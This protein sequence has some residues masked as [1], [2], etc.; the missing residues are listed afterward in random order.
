LPQLV[1]LKLNK[2]KTHMHI[3]RLLLASIERFMLDMRQFKRQ[4]E[5]KMWQHTP[6]HAYTHTHTH[7]HRTY[8]YRKLLNALTLQLFRVAL[9]STN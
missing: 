5:V 7:T 8:M 2:Q 3:F 6:T 4:D 9:L 1:A